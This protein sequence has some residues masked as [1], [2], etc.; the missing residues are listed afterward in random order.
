MPLSRGF[1]RAGSSEPAN[2]NWA[3]RALEH[4]SLIATQQALLPTVAAAI[5]SRRG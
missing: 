1:K 4:R 3:R 2:T 5:V